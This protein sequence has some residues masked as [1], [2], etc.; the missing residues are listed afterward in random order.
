M[1]DIPLFGFAFSFFVFAF[2]MEIDDVADAFVEEDAE[3]EFVRLW[4]G[5]VPW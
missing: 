2:R 3:L 4:F 5:E 1:R